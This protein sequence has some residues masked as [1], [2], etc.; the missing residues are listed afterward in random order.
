MDVTLD[1]TFW[2]DV[3]MA[4]A[5]RLTLVVVVLWSLKMVL[6][7][8]P[9]PRDTSPAAAIG[10]RV[11]ADVALTTNRLRRVLPPLENA[12]AEKTTTTTVAAE[13]PGRDRMRQELLAYLEQ[14][15]AGR[16]GR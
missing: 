14:R 11:N 8:R 12:T 13:R 5:V 10:N 6:E 2:W 4:V 16:T 3:G 7:R 1:A 9:V 15:T